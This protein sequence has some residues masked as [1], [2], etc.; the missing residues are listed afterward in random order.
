MI[1]VASSGVAVPPA[2]YVQVEF[3][4]SSSGDGFRVEFYGKPQGMQLALQKYTRTLVLKFKA[5]C[6]QRPLNN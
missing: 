3:Y 2:K 6:Q 1:D 4:T 5:V